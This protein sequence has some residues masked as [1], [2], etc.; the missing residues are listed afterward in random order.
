MPPVGEYDERTEIRLAVDARNRA[1]GKV[2]VA[3]EQDR[4]ERAVAAERHRLEP[5]PERV[6]EV[7]RREMRYGAEPG[8]PVSQPAGRLRRGV[9]QLARRLEFRRGSDR[10]RK[11]V[12][13]NL[14]DVFE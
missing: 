9:E 7:R 2:D 8:V 13:E 4:Q 11:D 1:R 5:E 14:A 6:G 12:F 3:L 10:Q